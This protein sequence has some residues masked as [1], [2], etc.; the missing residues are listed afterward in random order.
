[1]TGVLSD[2]RAKG[3]IQAYKGHSQYVRGRKIRIEVPQVEEEATP[4]PELELN[5]EEGEGETP[6]KPEPVRQVCM[7]DGEAMDYQS[8]I[9][10]ECF[11]GNIEV[12]IDDSYFTA[13]RTFER[14][15][16]PEYERE[17]VIMQVVDKIWSDFDADHSGQL[18]KPETRA[19][20]QKVLA[21]VPPPNAYDEA[22]FEE[23]FIAIDK[24]GNGLI[25]KNEMQFFVKSLLAPSP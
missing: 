17:R 6:Q 15:M 13:N 12:F 7:V 25:E 22:K 14:R 16:T 3:G 9:T 19:F 23:T 10:W 24:N 4:N 2:A 1:M 20:L 8:S 18:D 5:T 21:D 11:P